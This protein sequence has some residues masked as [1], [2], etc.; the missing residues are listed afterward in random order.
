[1]LT[2][3]TG[4]LL[5]ATC[6]AVEAEARARRQ[7]APARELARAVLF[8]FPEEWKDGPA[9]AFVIQ[10]VLAY[11]DGLKSQ[12]ED[13]HALLREAAI[14]YAKIAEVQ[15]KECGDLASAAVTQG[16]SLEIF[17]TL[18]RLLPDNAQAQRDLTVHSEKA[19]DLNR[20]TPQRICGGR[21]RVGS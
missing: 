20:A 6:R 15:R 7:L 9:R 14:T 18:A 1:M 3:C 5:L 13:D 8:D 2:H 10:A 17:K 11:L 4:G 19:A 21:G 12:A 16:K